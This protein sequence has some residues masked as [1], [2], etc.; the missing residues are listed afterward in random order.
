MYILGKVSE[1]A[2]KVFE[3]A[4]IL[5]IHFEYLVPTRKGFKNQEKL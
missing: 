4:G 1:V 3:I 5:N 2:G